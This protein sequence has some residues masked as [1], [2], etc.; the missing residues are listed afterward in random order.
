MIVDSSAAVAILLQEEDADML[1]ATLAARRARYMGAPTY[2]ETSMVVTGRRPNQ[3]A[4]RVDRF[5]RETEI[6]L[7]PFTAAAARVAVEAFLRYGKGRHKAG[8]NFGDCI[9]YAV[10]KTE[11]MPLLFKGDDFRLTDIEAAL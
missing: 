5:I 4:E 3:A 8:L 7:L 11:M 10:A 9:S 6:I 1:F 2:L